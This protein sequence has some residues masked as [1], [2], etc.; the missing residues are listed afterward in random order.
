MNEPHDRGALRP[1]LPDDPTYWEAL[2]YRITD[3]AEPV[4]AELRSRNA[5]WN[6]LARLAPAFGVGA[7]AATLAAFVALP[8]AVEPAVQTQEGAFA[9]L[10]DPGDEVG[11]VFVGG[12]APELASLLV[13][14]TGREP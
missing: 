8:A 11:A 3:S 14:Q 2:A 1:R 4:L 13:A 7:L 6:P 10:F 12:A 9:D 5:W